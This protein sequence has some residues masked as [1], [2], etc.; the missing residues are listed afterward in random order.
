MQQRYEQFL[1]KNT[2]IYIKNILR[3]NENIL[4][5]PITIERKKLIE[6]SNYDNN[7]LM[8]FERSI[9]FLIFLALVNKEK[10]SASFDWSTVL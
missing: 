8:P 9:I 1:K 7:F 10:Y 3:D 6:L 4:Y 2:S 5:C